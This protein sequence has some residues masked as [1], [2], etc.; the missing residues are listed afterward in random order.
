LTEIG[1]SLPEGSTAIGGLVLSYDRAQEVSADSSMACVSSV[2][3]VY[4][5]DD[6]TIHHAVVC[7][8]DAHHYEILSDTVVGTW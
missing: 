5:A 1:E 6:H 2:I 4:A 8:V 7:E 3:V